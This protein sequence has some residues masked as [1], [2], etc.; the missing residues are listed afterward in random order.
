MRRQGNE[1]ATPGCRGRPAYGPIRRSCAR[2]CDAWR[3]TANPSM[4]DARLEF[5]VVLFADVAD[6]QL[7]LVR[8]ESISV[9]VP[10]GWWR[11]A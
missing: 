7:P 1:V 8:A 6:A 11:T 2:N 3:T 5:G 4:D 9:T 10:P